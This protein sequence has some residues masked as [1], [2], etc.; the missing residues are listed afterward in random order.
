[1]VDAGD[2][3]MSHSLAIDG[4]TLTVQPTTG[5]TKFY[6][7]VPDGGGSGSAFFDMQCDG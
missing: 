4:G 5:D 3:T 1:M 6:L 2:V 7:R